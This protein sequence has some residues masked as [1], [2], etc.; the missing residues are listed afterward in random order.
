MP[1]GSVDTN[2]VIFCLRAKFHILIIVAIHIVSG[3]AIVG[4]GLGEHFSHKDKVDKVGETVGASKAD[5]KHAQ[6]VTDVVGGFV[7]FC[8]FL[9][10]FACCINGLIASAMLCCKSKCCFGYYAIMNTIALAATAY[11]AI[12]SFVSDAPVYTFTSISVVLWFKWT[13]RLVGAL[14]ILAIL[15]GAYCTLILCRLSYCDREVGGK[16]RLDLYSIDDDCDEDVE[17]WNRGRIHF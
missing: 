12:S 13:V 5:V 8:L 14:G 6:T 3:L 7:L 16:D 10:A 15:N 11:C 2:T 1:E 9:P 17:K 4:T